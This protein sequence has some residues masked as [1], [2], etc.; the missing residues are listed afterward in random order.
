M[1]QYLSQNVRYKLTMRAAK[2]ANADLREWLF[3]D[4]IPNRLQTLYANL[5][6]TSIAKAMLLRRTWSPLVPDWRFGIGLKLRESAAWMLHPY[7]RKDMNKKVTDSV[8]QAIMKSP[9]MVF[10]DLL[11]NYFKGQEQK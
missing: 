1:P 9:E 4:P 8:Q 11:R 7:W 2:I 6:K 3:T 5:A 10:T